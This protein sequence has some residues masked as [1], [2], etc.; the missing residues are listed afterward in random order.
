MKKC[1]RCGAEMAVRNN[2][3]TGNSFWGCSRWPH[4]RY[5]E[6]MSGQGSRKIGKGELV[7]ALAGIRRE[8]YRMYLQSEQW[9][10][11]RAAIIKLDNGKCQVC[12]AEKSLH[13]HHLTYDRIYDEAPYDLVT[14]CER[15]HE[16]IH[17]LENK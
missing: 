13:V 11:K 9:R 3:K 10:K 7:Q 12:G 14:V 1:P 17:K 5:T 16:A 8:R 15:C 4:C 2:K 6:T